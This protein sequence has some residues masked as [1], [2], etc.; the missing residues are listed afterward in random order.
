M[1][2]DIVV[3]ILLAVIVGEFSGSVLGVGDKLSLLAFGVFSSLAPDLDFLIYLWK[4]KGRV[5]Q[6]A[7]EHRDLL[8]HPL[9]FTGI[10][11][12]ILWA[13][14]VPGS[15]ILL[16]VAGTLWHFIHDTLAGGWG[17]RWLPGDPRYFTLTAY[18][19]KRVIQDKREQREI[20]QRYGDPDW[21][22][23]AK[24]LSTRSKWFMS[25]SMLLAFLWVLL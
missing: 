15:F 11:A 16:W 19:P 2:L 21:L 25:I 8:H 4:K 12:V 7:H 22:Q 9:L 10:G 1:V 18:S 3:G 5:D 24:R 23:K 13:A 6:F 17:I 14:F 20:A